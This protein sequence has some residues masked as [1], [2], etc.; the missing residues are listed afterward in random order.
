MNSH[1]KLELANEILV[2]RNFVSACKLAAVKDDGI[3]DKEEQKILDK[4]SKAAS[5][6]IVELEKIK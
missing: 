5:K 2:T 3:I 6:F 1:I 4:I